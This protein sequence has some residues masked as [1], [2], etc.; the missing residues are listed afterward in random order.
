MS[1]KSSAYFGNGS[2]ERA[3]ILYH[4]YSTFVFDDRAVVDDS[5]IGGA[6]DNAFQRMCDDLFS[7][8]YGYIK[9]PPWVSGIP[10]DPPDVR[11]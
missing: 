3:V 9:R 4:E 6:E 5:A 10:A 11:G 2:S 1:I 8:G 7:K